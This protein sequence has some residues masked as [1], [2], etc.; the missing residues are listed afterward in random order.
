MWQRASLFKPDFTALLDLEHYRTPINIP[1]SFR[2]TDL[3]Y[4]IY[5]SVWTAFFTAVRF[6]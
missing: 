3:W 4:T 6:T 5:R 1:M 2:Q